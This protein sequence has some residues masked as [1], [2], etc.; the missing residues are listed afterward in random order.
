MSRVRRFLAVAIIG[1]FSAIG[2]GAASALPVD[3]APATTASSVSSDVQQ[4]RWHHR[5]WHH[6]YRHHRH[7]R[8][9]YWHHGHWR[10]RHWYHRHWRHR[11]WR[12]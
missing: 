4:V 6:R 7:W 8:H 11:H 3:K 10:H 2:A 12:Y 1:A 5:H 9:R